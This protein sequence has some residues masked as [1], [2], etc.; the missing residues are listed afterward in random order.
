ML[1]CATACPA[2]DPPV[3]GDEPSTG[4]THAAT[5]LEPTADGPASDGSDSSPATTT[6]T[7]EPEPW[8]EAGWGLSDFNAYDGVLPVVVGPQGLSMFSVPLRGSGFYN[9]ASPGFD[10]PEVPVVQAWVD[11]DGHQESPG[12]HLTEVTEYPA[13]FYPTLDDPGVLQGVALWLVLPDGVDPNALVGLSASLHVEMID[14]EGLR[15][16]DDHDL[17]IG[18]VPPPPDGP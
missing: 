17:E 16:V 18:E 1:G 7:G 10:N 11:V 9:P 14:F 6:E 12:G 15:L 3:P 5:S 8:L 2:T 4:T 13:L